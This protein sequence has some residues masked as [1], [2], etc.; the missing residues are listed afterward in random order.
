MSFE[1]PSQPSQPD[2]FDQLYTQSDD[3]WQFKSRWYERRKR[4]LT[5]ACLPAQRYAYGF[6][7]GCSNGEL[8]ARLAT[9]CD[10]LLVSDGNDRA[11]ALS[12]ER[13][14]NFSNVELRQAWQ[15]KDWPSESFDLIVLSEFLFYLKPEAVAEIAAK[16]QATLTDGGVILACHWRHRFDQCAVTGDDAHVALKRLITLPQQCEL[17]ETDLRIDVWSSDRSVAQKEGLT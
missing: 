8:A 11:V 1:L 12:S 17:V 14:K 10:R 6:E 16:A 2:Y 15:P 3:P 13:L 7:P 4:T 5:L 9:R